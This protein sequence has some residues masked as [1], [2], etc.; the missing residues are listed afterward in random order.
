VLQAAWTAEMR[1][2]PSDVIVDKFLDPAVHSLERRSDTVGT[3][4]GKVFFEYASFCLTQLEDSSF[5]EDLERVKRLYDSKQS[6]VSRFQDALKK[7]PNLRLKRDKEKAEKDRRIDEEELA[8]LSALLQTLTTKAIEN[9]LRCFASCNTFDH[10]VP[11]FCA[12]WLKHFDQPF[13]NHAVAQRIKSVPSHKFI[14]LMHQLCARL[15]SDTTEFQD[16]LKGLLLRALNDHPF[17]VFPQ[18]YSTMHASDK[19]KVKTRLKP[20][21][22]LVDRMSY[23][24]KVGNVSVKDLSVRLAAQYESYSALADIPLNNGSTAL[25]F[26]SYPQLQSFRSASTLPPPSM[27]IPLSVQRHYSNVA[28]IQKYKGQ[29]ILASGINRPRIVDC[30]LSDGKGFRELVVSPNFLTDD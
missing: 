1:L 17:H 25:K 12:L 8:R 2:S 21:K 29:F 5:L 3:T 28:S 14:P 13:A 10:H 26:S 22:S 11:K 24:Q 6:E 20:A 15:S 7:D 16:N 30:T 27:P 23:S 19:S 18:M 4:A 9:F